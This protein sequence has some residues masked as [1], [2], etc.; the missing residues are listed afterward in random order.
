MA[1][2]MGL[3]EFRIQ[4]VLVMEVLKLADALQEKHYS[5]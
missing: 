5:V 3:G 1:D 2:E 4:L